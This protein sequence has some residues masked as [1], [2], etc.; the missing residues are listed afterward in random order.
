MRYLMV[1]VLLVALIAGPA[2]AALKVLPD[3]VVSRLEDA[4]LDQ[5]AGERDVSR[6]S[7]VIEEGWVRT[8]HHIGVDVYVV[9]IMDG[10]EKIDAYVHVEDEV[11]LTRAEFE[12]LVDSDTDN[13][14]D[15]VYVTTLQMTDDLESGS[16]T[17]TRSAGLPYYYAGGAVVIAG[18]TLMLL[19]KKRVS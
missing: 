18:A 11:V 5:V 13:A 7:L 1:A 16:E 8:L 3:E 17:A 15:T 2:F 10:D 9:M 19:N 6:D 4:V 14:G 12:A